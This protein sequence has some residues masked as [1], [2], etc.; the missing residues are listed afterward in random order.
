M[1]EFSLD[2]TH[3]SPT[4][5]PKSD[6]RALWPAEAGGS[7]TSWDWVTREGH[8]NLVLANLRL[9]QISDSVKSRTQANLGLR[10]I[11]DSGNRDSV[12]SRTQA[13]GTQANLGLCG[14]PVDS[15]WL[16]LCRG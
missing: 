9:R 5:K 8:G 10:Q 11:S 4:T 15:K 7:D 16:A 1:T 13:T 2:R 14:Y 12:K 3:K 6:S